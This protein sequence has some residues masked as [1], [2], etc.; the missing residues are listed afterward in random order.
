MRLISSAKRHQ[1]RHR[2]HNEDSFLCDDGLGLFA[3]ADGVESMPFG[4][5]AS[6]LCVD[7]LQKSLANLDLDDDATPPFE[8]AQ[9]IPLNARALKFAFRETNRAIHD[10][11]KTDK[12]YDG[13]STTLSA[14]WVTAGKVFIANVGDSR[15]YLI[16]NARMISLTKDHTTLSDTDSDKPIDLDIELFSSASEHELTRAM[17]LNPDVDVEL[18]AGTPKSGDYFVICTDGLYDSIKDFEIMD[19]VLANPPDMSVDYLITQANERGGK[20]NIAV[21][22]IKVI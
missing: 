6:K 1:G 7:T 9:G 17:G 12:K 21:V 5:V 2:Q 11:S 13:M 3:V 16:R 20:D 8:Y 10:N 4:E 15:S 18:A 22:V 14:L 19:T